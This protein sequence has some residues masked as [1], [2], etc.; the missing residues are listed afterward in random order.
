MCQGG[1]CLPLVEYY[2]DEDSD[3]WG[4]EYSYLSF[5]CWDSVWAVAPEYPYTSIQCGDCND[6]SWYIYPGAPEICCNGEDENCNGIEDDPAECTFTLTY[7]AG[8]G[9]FL[10]GATS[11]S[12]TCNETGSEVTAVPD[13]GYHFVDWSDGS[14][15]NPR[16]DGNLT[17]DLTVTANFA[18]NT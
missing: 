18:L 11:Q 1:E 5:V 4:R 17:A 12:L 16:S 15:Q 10:S 13:T 9:G 3:G 14:T 6:D 2:R 7:L 8:A